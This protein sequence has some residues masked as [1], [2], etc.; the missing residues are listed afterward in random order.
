MC[1]DDPE[2]LIHAQ[3]ELLTQRIEAREPPGGLFFLVVT[4]FE[5]T[6]VSRKSMRT[7][8]RRR[9]TARGDRGLEEELCSIGLPS[10]WGFGPCGRGFL[11][12]RWAALGWPQPTDRKD[13]QLTRTNPLPCRAT[14]RSTCSLPQFLSSCYRS[15]SDPTASDVALSTQ[16]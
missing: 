3:I 6:R 1:L 16:T 9:W 11:L 12:V 4:G 15:E 14:Q 7:S 13:A 5:K 8:S 10:S 2:Q